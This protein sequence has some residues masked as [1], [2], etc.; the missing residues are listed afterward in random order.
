[1]LTLSPSAIRRGTHWL[2]ATGVALLAVAAVSLAGARWEQFGPGSRLAILLGASALVL[3]A[4]QLV[5]RAAPETARALDVL[6]ATLVPLDVAA[7]V[8]VSGGSW[9]SALLAAGP[10]AIVAS[11]VLRRRDPTVI[12]ELGTAAGGIVAMAGAAALYDVS[13]PVLVATLGL[14]A[15]LATVRRGDRSFGVIWAA[16]AG[17]A[18]ALRVFDDAVFTGMGTLRD[19]GLLDAAE[20]WEMVLAGLIASVALVLA[21]VERRSAVVGLTAVAALAATG[22]QLWVSLDPPDTVG[23]IAVAVVLAAVELALA[24]PLADRLGRQAQVTIGDVNAVAAGML[25]AVAAASAWVGLTEGAVLADHLSPTAAVLALVWLLGDQRRAGEMG[26]RGLNRVLVGGNWAPALPGFV[27]AVASS[28]YLATDRT[29]V[30]GLVLAGLGVLALSSLRPGRLIVASAT[31][32]VAPFLV[33]EVPELA[34]TV[35]GVTT[36]ALMVVASFVVLRGDRYLAGLAAGLGVLTVLPGAVAAYT[37]GIEWSGLFVLVTLWAAGR[38]LDPALPLLGRV[39]RIV[40]W[41]GL[42]LIALHSYWLAMAASALAT[43]V[44]WIESRSGDEFHRWAAAITALFTWLFAMAG[45]GVDI[46]EVYVL[47]PFWLAM[48]ATSRLGAGRWESLGPA[49]ALTAV[50]TIESRIYDGRAVHMLILGC[51]A[52][53]LAIWGAMQGDRA[54]LVMGGSTAV[55]VAV[56]EGLAQSVGVETWGWLVVGGTAALTAAGLL[57]TRGSSALDEASLS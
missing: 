29:L 44:A 27:L 33:G 5:R 25:T 48:V 2:A 36:L 14:V 45:A 57:E 39:F 21:A 22:I 16:A 40:A 8:I 23:F 18:P 24:H 3:G 47:P 53:G 19:L 37:F 41:S 9:P 13:A 20:P 15:V 4:T 31:L 54:A 32:T 26:Q 35:S 10:T 7:L 50:V 46:A 12:T 28:V 42:G 52:V 49:A 55:A 34:M 51:F 1:M 38:L 56:Y 6:V 17:L 11:E 30:L 43:L